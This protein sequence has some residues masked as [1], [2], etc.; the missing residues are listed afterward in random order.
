[1]NKW[2]YILYNYNLILKIYYLI[3]IECIN[4]RKNAIASYSSVNELD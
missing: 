1:M 4:I 3:I 2:L